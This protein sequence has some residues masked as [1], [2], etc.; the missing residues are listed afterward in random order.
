MSS[1]RGGAAV[2]P[3]NG[4]GNYTS[5]V[6][7]PLPSLN[8]PF[9]IYL[10]KV[11]AVKDAASAGVL[12]PHHLLIDIARILEDVLVTACRVFL[13]NRGDDALSRPLLLSLSHADCSTSVRDRLRDGE[14]LSPTTWREIEEIKRKAE[15]SLQSSAREVHRHTAV[16]AIAMAAKL[17]KELAD[18]MNAAKGGVEEAKPRSGC[19]A[20]HAFCRDMTPQHL[21]VV[22]GAHD[23]HTVDKNAARSNTGAPA[24]GAATES[25]G[26]ILAQPVANPNSQ[27]L[28]PRPRAHAALPY[29]WDRATF[30]KH[31][32][33]LHNT[34]H[35][36]LQSLEEAEEEAEK[37]EAAKREE[38]RREALRIRNEAIQ[39]RK[40][41][42]EAEEKARAE[43]LAKSELGPD[44]QLSD[45]E[46]D[47]DEVDSED[48]RA[49]ERRAARAAAAEE[50]EEEEEEEIN[51]EDDEDG[52]LRAAQAERKAALAARRAE[53]AADEKL[54]TQPLPQAPQ[55]PPRFAFTFC[56]IVCHSVLLRARD[57]DR[58]TNNQVWTKPGRHLAAAGKSLLKN[59]TDV[60]FTRP[61]DEKDSE[62]KREDEEEEEEEVAADEEED[63]ANTNLDP[64]I[65]PRDEGLSKRESSIGVH[66]AGCDYYVGRYFTNKDAFRLIYIQRS[67]GQNFMY[68]TGDASPER[69]TP[70]MVRR[71]ED[72]EGEEEAG[73]PV[74]AE[75]GEEED[76]EA[77]AERVAQLRAAAKAALPI[78]PVVGLP[79]VYSDARQAPLYPFPRFG[80]LTPYQ[81]PSAWERYN[82]TIMRP[83]NQ[84]DNAKQ[85]EESKEED[86]SVAGGATP[87]AK[88]GKVKLNDR[89]YRPSIPALPFIYAM[90]RQTPDHQ[91]TLA[92][93]DVAAIKKG[94]VSADLQCLLS[95]DR[96]FHSRRQIDALTV[97]VD[98]LFTDFPRKGTV[99]ANTLHPP[100]PVY[101][102]FFVKDAPEMTRDRGTARYVFHFLTNKD[103]SKLKRVPYT[104]NKFLKALI[105]Y[106]NSVVHMTAGGFGGHRFVLVKVG[107]VFRLFQSNHN[108]ESAK[109]RYT[110]REWIGMAHDESTLPLPWCRTM[111]YPTLLLFLAKFEEARRG[112][113]EVWEE[114]FCRSKRALGVYDVSDE[115][116]PDEIQ[117]SIAKLIDERVQL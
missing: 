101:T 54:A 117:F 7:V 83:H 42:R 107:G 40:E 63:G 1:T 24:A 70:A 100:V 49:S 53:D 48:E 76:D 56:C 4:N 92:L 111:D 72:E 58:I 108:L 57:I 38:E 66:C 78:P 110:C 26:P 44:E 23:A 87:K 75:Q 33:P 35:L 91:Y 86:A 2:A 102:Y 11:N 28:K 67:S 116:K 113:R 20:Q 97:R 61:A 81:R 16:D 41:R 115:W 50:E 10:T 5:D 9:G 90:L 103:D 60:A 96:Q 89:K 64:S 22:G 15:W 105:R 77:F 73:P 114:L 80:S 88:A 39:R 65:P 46:E 82:E 69:L 84:P 71:D 55:K 104:Y 93:S 36:D 99:Y 21:A 98:D 37:E 13:E 74:D 17:C 47:A 43:R 32:R 112:K 79:G 51:S 68:F 6:E 14:I 59:H 85:A 45:L 3:A 106:E 30:E 109:D 31:C 29:G 8:D 34:A 25:S 52:S 27:D 18:Q 12:Q 62:E 19:D 95:S 94:L